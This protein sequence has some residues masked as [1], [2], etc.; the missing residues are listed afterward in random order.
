MKLAKSGKSP[1]ALA[2]ESRRRACQWIYH[3][4]YTSAGII[5]YLLGR[6]AGGY[7][8]RLVRQG[9]LTQTKTASGKPAAIFTLTTI[10]LEIAENQADCLMRYSEL[11][12]QKVNQQL[13]RH[14]LLAQEITMKA[15]R[16]GKITGYETERMFV[17]DRDQLGIKRPD[18]VWLTSSGQ[19]LG[20][21]IE[22]SAKWGRDLDEFVLGIAR[23]LAESAEQSAK[24]NRF[25]VAS[26][27]R[28]IIDRY[29]QAVSPGAILN[30]WKKNER[31]HWVVDKKR[32]VPDWLAG[33]VDFQFLE[34]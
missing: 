9:I 33:K 14:N 19:R 34:V 21:E 30:S 11:D 5:Q 27:C 18:V 32:Q 31:K 16:S 20:I 17:A 4:G 6:T 15:I 7:A 29:V 8:Q 26:D 3:W 28:A 1:N 10:G 25:V 23:G 22:L 2:E 24:Y 12:P 13:I